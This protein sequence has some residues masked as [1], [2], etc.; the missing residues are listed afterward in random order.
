MSE[1]NKP[2]VTFWVIG[3]IALIWNG[4]GS[5]MYIAQAYDMEIA[6]K[7]LS[8]EQIA[9]LDNMPSWYTA[10]FALAVFAGLLG[11]ITLLL[12]KKLAAPLFVISFTCA[13]IN[14]IYWLFATEASTVFA[15]NQPYVMPML[16]IA[17]GLIFIWYSRKMK[18]EGILS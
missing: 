7:D 12:K 14:Q 13:L 18:S 9:F 16:I 15:E 3:I 5:F 2:G 8:V 17:L 6:S 10:L 11:A 1:S 4:W